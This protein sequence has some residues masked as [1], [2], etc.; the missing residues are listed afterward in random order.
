M[1]YGLLKNASASLGNI[2]TG[3]TAALP[4]WDG[5]DPAIVRVQCILYSSLGASLLAAFIAMLG[6]QWV[7][8]YAQTEIRGSVV[9][10]SRY[11]QYKMNGMIAWR[12]DIFMECS[13]LMLQAALL[14]LGYALSGYLSCTNETVASIVVS[15]TT[16]GLLFY[17]LVVSVG[18]F[19]YNCPFQTP[20][21]LILRHLFHFNDGNLRQPRKWFG[22]ASSQKKWPGLKSA[23][24]YG[25]DR[26]GR[27]D[28]SPVELPMAEQPPQLFEESDWGGYVLDAN[29]IALMFEMSM[30]ADAVTTIMKFIPEVVWH[31]GIRNTPLEELYDAVLECFDSPTWRP[32]VIPKLRNEAYFSA[33][34]L[35][36]VVI[37]RKCIC[38][39][40][41]E[42][43]FKSISTLHATMGSKHY[44]GDSDLESTLGIIDR[45]FGDFKPM[46][47]QDFSFTIPHHAW[48]GHIL[49]YRTWDIMRKREPLPDDVKEF[50][51]HSLR[52][53]PPPP[54]PIVADCLF[55]VGLILGIGLHVY[56]LL[57]TDKR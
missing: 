13:P 9:D 44:E 40:S 26:F 7:N 20:L 16:F 39:E 50:V 32:A 51:S 28:G 57:V 17:F 8:R 22:Q 49:L 25:L 31:A 42:A 47:W 33:K 3:T 30:G 21:S 29:C 45:V 38:G 24:S 43:A 19:S 4:R 27:F 14:L 2:L 52:L 18:T 55:I 53:E 36:H 48:M 54:A 35:L 15:F 41:D 46:R 5:P 6:R 23:G 37:Q 11:R 12:F 10:R 34:A 1:S 56:D